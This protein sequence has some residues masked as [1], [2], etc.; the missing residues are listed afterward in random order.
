MSNK[1]IGGKTLISLDSKSYK[2]FSE[3]LNEEKGKRIAQEFLRDIVFS[4]KSIE[5]EMQYMLAA[6]KKGTPLDRE[7]FAKMVTVK[8]KY[9]QAMH[10]LR[11][12]EDKARHAL[13]ALADAAQDLMTYIHTQRKQ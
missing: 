6:N 2:R 4:F 12:N 13:I 9:L 1:F 10:A 7:L 5:E 11:E 3:T 8:E